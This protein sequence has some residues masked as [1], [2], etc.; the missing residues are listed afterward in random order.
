MDGQYYIYIITNKNN[1]VLY[2]GQTSSLLVR[3][4]QHKQGMAD[5][6]SKHYNANKLV[7]Y[8]IADDLDS[9][10]YREKQ[11]KGYARRKKLC[12]VDSFNPGWKDL[13]ST[14]IE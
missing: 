9:A 7:Y 3:M 13:T 1:T 14:I 8:E 2:T 11:I 5:G 4:D 6:F 10:L 12:L